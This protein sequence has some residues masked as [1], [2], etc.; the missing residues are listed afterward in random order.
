MVP[1]SAQYYWEE[2][3]EADGTVHEYL[4]IDVIIWKRQEAYEKIKQNKITDES[5]EIK[6]I[7]GEMI[8]GYYHIYSFEFTAFCLLES[9]EP[10]YES[11]RI[12][13][14]SLTNFRSEYEDMMEDF[15][16]CFSTVKTSKEEDI[17]MQ[18]TVNLSKGGNTALDKIKLLG[19]YGLKVEDIDFKIEDFGI[20]KLEEKFKAIKQKNETQDDNIG[21]S[22]ATGDETG[23]GSEEVESGEGAG[24]ADGGDEGKD[25]SLS[26]EQFR[27][28]LIDTLCSVHYTDPYWGETCKYYY[29]DHDVEN[30]E[31]Y[32]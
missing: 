15:K 22:D 23:E 32:C 19:K 30:K 20:T 27:E 1:E 10:C 7:S 9:A 14:F 21:S 16:K 31:V 4:C 25:F 8:D 28:Q 2:I 17:H 5:M 26:A 3:T 12:E 6:V 24:V 18:N 13:M 29:L 11:A